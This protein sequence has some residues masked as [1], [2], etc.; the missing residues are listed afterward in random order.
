MWWKNQY[1]VMDMAQKHPAQER[2]LARDRTATTPSQARS[3]PIFARLLFIAP[4]RL[5]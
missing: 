4:E 1:K 5:F 2:R 3:A